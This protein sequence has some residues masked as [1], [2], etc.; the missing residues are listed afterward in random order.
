MS[1]SNVVIIMPLHVTVRLS[2]LFELVVMASPNRYTALC[3]AF[4]DI[5]DLSA[6]LL[7]ASNFFLRA[8]EF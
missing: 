6:S 4:A 3:R 8:S 2:L 1:P 5:A 7:A